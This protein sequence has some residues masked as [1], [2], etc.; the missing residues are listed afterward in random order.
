VAN[1]FKAM[2]EWLRVLKSGGYLLLVLPHKDG[3]FDHLRPVTPFQ[4]L[5]DDY[6]RSVG[7]DDLGHLPE[8]LELHDLSMDPPAGD[9]ESFRRRSLKNLENRCLHH[10][11]FDTDLTV[12]ML[13]HFGLQVLDV[14]Q[15]LPYHIIT[16]SRKLPGAARPDN[17]SFL[18]SAAACR[19]NSPFSTDRRGPV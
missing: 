2:A 7:E 9:R 10:H 4:H 14:Q 17:N 18:S 8:I 16:L 12:R 13:D 15:A 3:T 5:V 6:E 19:K 11:A 1:P